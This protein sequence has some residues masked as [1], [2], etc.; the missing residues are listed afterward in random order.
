ML[1]VEKTDFF[2]GN[3]ENIFYKLW[4]PREHIIVIGH[5]FIDGRVRELAGALAGAG[6]CNHCP[7]TRGVGVREILLGPCSLL[8]VALDASKNIRNSLP[9]LN[10]SPSLSIS[11]SGSL[12]SS[13]SGAPSVSLGHHAFIDADTPPGVQVR[14]NTIFDNS[15]SLAKYST[16]ILVPTHR[17]TP[18]QCGFLR[19]HLLVICAAKPR[20][21]AADAREHWR[22]LAPCLP[23]PCASVTSPLHNLR[24]VLFE[25]CQRYVLLPRLEGEVRQMFSIARLRLITAPEA[26]VRPALLCDLLCD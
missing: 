10:P 4:K 9:P 23:T 15:A 14:R 13:L 26:R 1:S 22:V 8:M 16:H 24:E 2:Y 18:A 25:M 17:Q 12:A 11:L 19:S 6:H 21:T 3:R 20:Y 5:F 7:C